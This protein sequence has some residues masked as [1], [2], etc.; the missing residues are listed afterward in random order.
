MQDFVLFRDCDL[1][2]L[3]SSA[4]LP[5][6]GPAAKSHAAL[7]QTPPDG[8]DNTRIRTWGPYMMNQRADE[9]ATIVSSI[10]LQYRCVLPC[11]AV[12]T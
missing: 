11:T 4:A 12:R 2:G 9:M 6:L 3:V 7:V 1:K 5:W 10:T 8:Q